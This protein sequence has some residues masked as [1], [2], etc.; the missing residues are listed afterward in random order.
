MTGDQQQQDWCDQWDLRP[1][2]TYLNHGSFGPPPRP[3][4]A[5]RR[6][7]QQQLDSQPMDFF[8]RQYEPALQAAR[9][10]LA[11]F[12]GADPQDLVFV[13]NATAAMNVVAN[14]L[15]LEHNDQVL[16]TDHEYG[17][18]HRIW[19]RATLR[20]GSDQPVIAALPDRIESADQL[21]DRLL[22]AF[23]PRTRLLVISHI[24]SPTAITMPIETIVRRAHQRGVLVCVDGPH[25]PAQI[26]LDLS[27]LGCDFY[28]A[29]LHKWL[30][31]PFGSGFLYVRREHQSRITPTQI[32]WGRLLPQRP[33]S[34]SD[35]F[36]WSGTRDPSALLTVPAAIG[37]LQEA[38]LGAFREH[39]YR[40]A[41]EARNRLAEWT[42][43]PPITPDDR[44]WYTCMGHAPLPSGDASGLQR[45]LWQR[46]AIEVPIVSWKDRYWLRVSCHLYN[47][48]QDIDRLFDALTRELRT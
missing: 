17:A 45:A 32:S 43:L 19:Q 30:S 24:T 33:E 10:R 1:G 9:Q 38:G 44:C 29:S 5:E 8:D 14:S 31:A 3:V 37:F 20:A 27:A 42:G 21:V 23:T 13:E 22:D 6:Q 25:A 15:R 46:H 36:I 16:L 28:C 40:L 34:W 4:Q 41:T 18:V 7:W 26:P 47:R 48:R 11:E 12:V 2:V 39:G 35:E